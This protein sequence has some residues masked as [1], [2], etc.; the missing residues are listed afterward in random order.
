MKETTPTAMPPCFDKWCRRER[1]Y[2]YTHCLKKRGLGTIWEDYW[3]KVSEKPD[4]A[5]KRYGRS[6][7][8]PIT[9]FFDRSSQGMPSLLMSDGGR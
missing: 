5:L 1:R 9:S 8:S 4:S 6:D 3:E 2:F 7:L